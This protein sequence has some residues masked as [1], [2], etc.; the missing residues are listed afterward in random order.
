MLAFAASAAV[1]MFVCPSTIGG[2]SPANGAVLPRFADI[3]VAP[4][5]MTELA[6]TE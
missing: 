6:S 3:A 5:L 4:L 2:T 1:P